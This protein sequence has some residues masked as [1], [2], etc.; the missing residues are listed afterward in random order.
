MDVECPSAAVLR[1]IERGVD[2]G[3][4]G[5]R[6]TFPSREERENLELHGRQRKASRRVADFAAFEVDLNGSNHQPFSA[7]EIWAAQTGLD[8]RDELFGEKRLGYV[9]VGA[10]LEPTN[11][12]RRVVSRTQR[13]EPEL[14]TSSGSA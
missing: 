2:Q 11:L 13:S 12:V 1:W 9:V 5:D 8:A 10:E 7:Y 3:F 14:R 6:R 4:S